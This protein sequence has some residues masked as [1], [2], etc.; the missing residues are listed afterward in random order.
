MKELS[1]WGI[2]QISLVMPILLLLSVIMVGVFIERVLY[3]ARMGNIDPVLFKNIKEYV[4]G[5]N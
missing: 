4:V 5:G 1:F 2:L 3:F